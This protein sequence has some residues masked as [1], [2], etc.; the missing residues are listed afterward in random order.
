MFRLNWVG[1]LRKKVRKKVVALRWRGKLVAET[2]FILDEEEH[3][4]LNRSLR[5]LVVF[6]RGIPQPHLLDKRLNRGRF[7]CSLLRHAFLSD[8]YMKGEK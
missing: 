8:G 3:S 6:F 2:T 5:F 1:F 4:M 7:S